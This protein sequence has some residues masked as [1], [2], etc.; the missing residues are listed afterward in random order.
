MEEGGKHC[1]GPREDEGGELDGRQND[2]D[3]KGGPDETLT[4][5]L[6]LRG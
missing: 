1:E 6:G 3:G 4:H 2:V 5:D